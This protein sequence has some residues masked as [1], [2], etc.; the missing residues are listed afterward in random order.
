MVSSTFSEGTWHVTD[1]NT[2]N[3]LTLALVSLD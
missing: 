2:H 1:G 3:I